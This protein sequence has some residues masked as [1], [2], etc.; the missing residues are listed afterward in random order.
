MTENDR[1]VAKPGQS[2]GGLILEGA[3][4]LGERTIR[5]VLAEADS[6]LIDL[7]HHSIKPDELALV[8]GCL[9]LEPEELI[10]RRHAVLA[11]DQHRRSFFGV[12][13]DARL[14]EKRTRRFSPGT[15]RENAWHR[16]SWQLRPLPFCEVSWTFVTDKCHACGTV[17]GWSRAWGPELCDTCATTLNEGRT[18]EVPVGLQPALHLAAGLLHHDDNRRTESLNALPEELR[19][20]GPDGCMDV[21]CAVA[22]VVDPSLRM[23]RH[24]HLLDGSAEPARIARAVADAWELMRGW[25]DAFLAECDRRLARRAGRF[26]DGN[27]GATQAFLSFAEREEMPRPLRRAVEDL[28][29]VIADRQEGYLDARSFSKASGVTAGR[30]ARSRRAGLVRSVIGLNDKGRITPMLPA[31]EAE[32]SRR[33]AAEGIMV[34]RAAARLGC[35]F[36][37]VEELIALGVLNPSPDVV[38][39]SQPDRRKIEI[40]S[41]DGLFD[42]LLRGGASPSDGGF[43]VTLKRAMWSVGGRLKPWSAAFVTLLEGRLPFA[44]APGDEPLA[45][46]I[47]LRAS[48]LPVLQSLMN[49]FD[50]ADPRFADHMSKS[51]AY[52]VLN[53][54]GRVAEGL[55]DRWASL[56]GLYRT[57]PAV[58]VLRLAK[59]LVSRREL[60][61]RIGTST[62]RMRG[63]L[64]RLDVHVREGDL[65]DREEALVALGC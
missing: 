21:L 20:L 45:T 27:G 51:D 24:R 46:R 38:D 53:T 34:E 6:S 60:A 62:H 47:R 39:N 32:R 29:G 30:V 54:E 23:D 63:I 15:L 58:D 43:D 57:V 1:I 31:S 48:A 49:G 40:A 35:T 5:G 55:L 56:G 52:D 42:R 7:M 64:S 65:Y 59:R 2:L 17:Q 9:D 13:I 22:G 33:R 14:L 10:A 61:A 37:A 44:L 18:D 16:A 4:A 3:A 19:V 12:A 26:G 11:E 28:L 36:R 25:P 41:L 50:E 8:A